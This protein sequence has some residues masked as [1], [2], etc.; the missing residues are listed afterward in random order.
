M[1]VGYA[2]VSSSNQDLQIQQ[3]ALKNQDASKYIVK[4]LV[5]KNNDRPKL[6]EM[7]N[8]LREGDI[9]VVYKK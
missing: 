5:E 8:D 9:V 4:P 3:E 1:K 2:R 7:L 6:T